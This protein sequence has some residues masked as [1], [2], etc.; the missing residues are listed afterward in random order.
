MGSGGVGGGRGRA[1]SFDET[2]AAAQR[3]TGQR[4]GRRQVEQIASAAAGLHCR[5]TAEL[6][7]A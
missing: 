7:R 4:V 6:V 5:E 3:A 1:G 2:I